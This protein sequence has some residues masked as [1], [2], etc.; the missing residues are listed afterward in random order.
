[1]SI[2][3]LP[4]YLYDFSFVMFLNF[5]YTGFQNF[6]SYILKD[7]IFYSIINGIKQHYRICYG[8]QNVLSVNRRWVTWENEFI[9]TKQCNQDLYIL[10]YLMY[11]FSVRGYFVLPSRNI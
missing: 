9:K 8:E 11:W 7:F 10:A 3:Y 1:M 6:I 5:P 2:K 4:D